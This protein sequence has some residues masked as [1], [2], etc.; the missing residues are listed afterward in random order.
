MPPS[1][2]SFTSEPT[3]ASS[4]R[5]LPSAEK[6]VQILSSSILYA[7]RSPQPVMTDEGYPRA[8]PLPQ[9]RMT[10]QFMAHSPLP[11]N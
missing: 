4:Y 3:A 1:G 11:V 5:P 10:L 8:A 6:G 2:I 9:G 7:H